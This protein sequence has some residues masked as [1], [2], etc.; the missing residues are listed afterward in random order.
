M[1]LITM[2]S[3]QVLLAYSVYVVA[4]ASPG[5]SNL[6]IM[7]I[8]MNQ[9]RRAALQFAA[10]VGG[11]SFFWALLAA[12]GLSAR[13]ARYAQALGGVKMMGGLYLL[14][15][16]YR[17]ACSALRH[18]R[19]AAPVGETRQAGWQLYLR[20]LGLHISNPKAIL[21]WLSIVAIALPGGASPGAALQVVAGCMGLGVLLFG[22]Y[23]LAFSTALAR[24]VY[25]AVRRWFDAALAALFGTAGTQ[26]LLSPTLHL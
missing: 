14:W 6:A 9:G 15:L 23:A 25:A 24:R 2:L 7:G 12:L 20:G 5:P 3:N 4:V 22:G 11:G 10:G 17:A 8:A 19:P 13:L 1:G 21:S 18:T 16:A 26:L